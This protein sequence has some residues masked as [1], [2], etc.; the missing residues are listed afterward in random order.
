[1]PTKTRRCFPNQQSVGQ[2]QS[3]IYEA[4]NLTAEG[5]QLIEGHDNMQ[6]NKHLTNRAAIES[7]PSCATAESA[8]GTK[9]FI[10]FYH[11]SIS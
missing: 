9:A 7:D 2:D 6:P 10:D 3:L 4:S 8:Q 5:T 11:H 1:M